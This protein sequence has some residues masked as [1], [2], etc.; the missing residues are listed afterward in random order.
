[1]KKIAALSLAL[2]LALSLTVASAQTYTAGSYYT[3]DYPDTLTLDDTSYTDENTADNTWLY[4]LE[5]EDYLIDASIS[6]ASGYEGF[7]LYS[8]SDADRQAYVDDTLDAYADDNA[9]LVDT[10]TVGNIP[11]YIFSME[12]SDGPYYYA[13]T[14]A[15][16][17]SI[18]FCCYYSDA[19]ATPDEALLKDLETVLGT[20]KPVSSG[21]VTSSA[22]V[23]GG[24]SA[25]KADATSGATSK[26]N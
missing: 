26:K 12:D 16:G 7:S 18:N 3:I 8:A 2:L 20:F 15:N 23:S 22:S 10:L 11:F 1:M 19:G 17:A 6:T 21:A 13:E 14:L 25:G 5:G 9:A 24:A 4:M